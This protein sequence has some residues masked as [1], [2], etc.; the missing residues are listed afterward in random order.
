M[1]PNSIFKINLK[2]LFKIIIIIGLILVIIYSF[3]HN[4]FIV[5][6]NFEINNFSKIFNLNNLILIKLYNFP[7]NKLTWLII[8]YLLITL[9]IAAKLV[10]NNIGSLRQLN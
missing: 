5:K 1:A 9:I 7:I 10:K 6:N 8:L 3:I 2:L 4:N